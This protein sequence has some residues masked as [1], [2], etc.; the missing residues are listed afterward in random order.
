MTDIKE[1]HGLEAVAWQDA[2]NPLYTTGEKRQMHGWATDGY[3][4]VPLCSL[5]KA[6]AIIDQL[7]G[8]IASF[9]EGSERMALKGI[10]MRLELD[11]QAA[12]IA[13]YERA[14]LVSWPEGAKGEVCDLWNEARTMG[15]KGDGN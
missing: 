6:Q 13:L 11:Q 15:S 4:I 10:E 3:P 14:L 8:T 5:P 1:A 7:Q 9:E 2:E 12:R